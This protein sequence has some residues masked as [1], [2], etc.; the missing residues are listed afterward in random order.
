MV[1]FI[2]EYWQ[3]APQTRK[4]CVAI[5][6]GN[7]NRYYAKMVTVG[8]EYDTL[9]YNK[10]GNVF[11]LSDDLGNCGVV[12]YATMFVDVLAE[13]TFHQYMPIEALQSPCQCGAF[14]SIKAAKGPLHS[15]WCPEYD[16]SGKPHVETQEELVAR[17]R[18]GRKGANP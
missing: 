10:S 15:H 6:N 2:P 1:I 4:R 12:A 14:K 5:D 18:A 13:E 11:I 16:S 9:Q 3:K 17:V 7:G 8:K